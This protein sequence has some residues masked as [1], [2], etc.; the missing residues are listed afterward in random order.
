VEGVITQFSEAE[1]GG[2]ATQDQRKEEE[3]VQKTILIVAM[4][5]ALP[6]L[7]AA[8]TVAPVESQP[9]WCGGSYSVT[10]GLDAKAYWAAIDAGSVPP[11]GT[12]FGA[13][14]PIAREVRGPDGRVSV[15]S[16]PTYPEYAASR[17]SFADGGRV[18]FDTGALDKAGHPVLVELKVPE[19]PKK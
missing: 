1:Q 7:A 15:V 10:G 13:C 18:L 12:N 9:A 16:I 6:V 11:A 19:R 8:Q 3:N 4:I 17:V 2:A 5:L 14:E